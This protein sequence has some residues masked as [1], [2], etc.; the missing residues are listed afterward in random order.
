V[1]AFHIPSFDIVF[2]IHCAGTGRLCELD[3]RGYMPICDEL[4]DCFRQKL[5]GLRVLHF[6]LGVSSSNMDNVVETLEA[7][8]LLRD[9]GM[10]HCQ[11]LFARQQSSM[12]SAQCRNL[13]ALTLTALDPS[14][15]G[16]IA[17][18][19][20]DLCNLISLDV[21]GC[22]LLYSE[23]AC[24]L[25]RYCGGLQRLVL[26]WSSAPAE[27]GF[28]DS[29]VDALHQLPLLQCLDVSGIADCRDVLI[30][31]AARHCT[32]LR[33]LHMNGCG[34]L[35][36]ASIHAFVQYETPLTGLWCMHC[37][38]ITR[39]ALV[40]LNQA[41]RN[42]HIRSSLYQTSSTAAASEGAGI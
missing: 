25:A 2:A 23:D 28:V 14:G 10:H 5:L 30:Q 22:Q 40:A 15:A 3:L 35:T 20:P 42:V 11:F 24:A 33:E 9:F 7:L 38:Q 12:V 17:E 4:L 6:T 31:A 27:A 39:P 18:M 32:Q 37:R 8:P 41:N 26:A 19:A 21:R 36:D 29:L 13:T 1:Q 34:L 16:F